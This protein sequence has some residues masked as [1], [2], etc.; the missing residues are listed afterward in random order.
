MSSEAGSY[1]DEEQQY[2]HDDIESHADYEE[3]ASQFSTNCKTH[4]SNQSEQ[5]PTKHYFHRHNLSGLVLTISLALM[6][7]H[8]FLSDCALVFTSTA[9]A[10]DTARL[11]MVLNLRYLGAACYF[12][13]AGAWPRFLV[14][15]RNAEAPL[16][17][18]A[19]MQTYHALFNKRP[20]SHV[21][22]IVF[23]AVA[24]LA[25]GMPLVRIFINPYSTY[26]CGFRS[27]YRSDLARVRRFLSM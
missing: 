13:L 5:P 8:A 3:T 1:V 19:V 12:V 27:I 11:E 2:S 21:L 4:T 6:Y 22:G 18:S 17:V 9:A 26:N 16:V 14:E 23:V 24:C 15:W 10:S 25:R 20:L 7:A